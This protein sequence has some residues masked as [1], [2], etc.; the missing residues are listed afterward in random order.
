[1]LMIGKIKVQLCIRNNIETS[2][3][4]SQMCC[5]HVRLVPRN[6][7]VITNW[8]VV[9]SKPTEASTEARPTEF[10]P[11]CLSGFS[12][13]QYRRNIHNIVC[14]ESVATH[15]PRLIKLGDTS[16][17]KRYIGLCTH[18]IEYFNDIWR[19]TRRKNQRE[20]KDQKHPRIYNP[21]WSPIKCIW[22]LKVCPFAQIM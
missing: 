16:T 15:Q 13:L 14:L 12:N 11:A 20:L 2:T 19:M 21:V 10:F 5:C 17:W 3:Q 18:T 8:E 22:L 4:V 7:A 9:C 6:P 1:M